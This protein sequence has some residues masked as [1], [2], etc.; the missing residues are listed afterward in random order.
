MQLN[1]HTCKL[2]VKHIKILQLL[3]SHNKHTVQPDLTAWHLPQRS[4][5]TCTLR[6][7][8]IFTIDMDVHI[9]KFASIMRALHFFYFVTCL[10]DS[11]SIFKFCLMDIPN[12]ASTSTLV[13]ST[14]TRNAHY[15]WL[16][17]LLLI[18]Q[19]KTNVIH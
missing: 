16:Q 19:Q 14:S 4:K 5:V 3:S 11:F 6:T 7:F 12:I 2:W 10:L 17:F 15:H 9:Y 8:R 13:S 18:P 1:V